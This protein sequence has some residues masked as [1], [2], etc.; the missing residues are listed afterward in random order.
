VECLD[1]LK[2]RVP[3]FVLLDIQMP[4][5]SGWE[6]YDQIRKMPNLGA[7]PLIALTAHAMTGDREKALTYGFNGYIP[8]PINALTLVDDIEAILSH[9]SFPARKL[10]IVLIDDDPEIHRVLTI[11]TSHLEHRLACFPDAEQAF[12][13]LREQ[14]GKPDIIIIDIFMPGMDGYRTLEVLRRDKLAPDA[15]LVAM[16]SYYNDDTKQK[17]LDW[18]F[19]YY[20]PKPINPLTLGRTLDEFVQGTPAPQSPGVPGIAD[21]PAPQN[22]SPG[23]TPG[24]AAATDAASPGTPRP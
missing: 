21:H 13:Y 10:D 4:H 17:V 22:P 2:E 12:H 16:T 9:K 5:M 20:L 14:I 24:G 8:K 6:T 18:G 7:L 15:K 3:S 23:N 1:L 19:H 11:I